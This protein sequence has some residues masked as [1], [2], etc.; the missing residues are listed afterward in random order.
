MRKLLIFGERELEA[1]NKAL[2]TETLEDILIKDG[3]VYLIC[4][5]DTGQYGL[6]TADQV[7][8]VDKELRKLM[9]NRISGELESDHWQ[10]KRLAKTGSPKVQAENEME[11]LRLT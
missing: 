5:A 3:K 10:S 9:Q 8:L 2:Q 7:I 4:R 1:V 6:S 11:V